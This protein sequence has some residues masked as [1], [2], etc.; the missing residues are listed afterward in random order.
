MRVVAIQKG[1][2]RS[3]LLMVTAMK[4]GLKGPR[5]LLPTRHSTSY[6]AGGVQAGPCEQVPTP[7]TLAG[8]HGNSASV[9][10]RC[11]SV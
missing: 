6:T 4:S 5:K 10:T 9:S 11:P 3:G 1:P 8:N 7:S 2:Y